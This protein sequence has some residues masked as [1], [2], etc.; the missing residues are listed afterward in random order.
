LTGELFSPVFDGSLSA[1]PVTIKDILFHDAAGKI[2]FRDKKVLFSDVDIRQLGS[3]YILDGSIDFGRGDIFYDARLK[4]VRSDVASV[5]ALFY[6]PL[7]LRISATGEMTFAGTRKDFAGK[8]ALSVGP[9][10]PRTASPFQMVPSRSHSLGNGSRSRW[11]WCTW[12]RGWW[13]VTAGS[14][15]TA[16]TQPS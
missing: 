5:V 4:V 7:P 6:K 15:L 9:A 12:G 10:A 3:R 8:G 14:D 1:G 13:R 2:Q 16:P 11:S